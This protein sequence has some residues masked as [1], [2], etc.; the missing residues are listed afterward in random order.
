[1][2]RGIEN[3]QPLRVLEHLADDQEAVAHV[4]AMV[5]PGLCPV[6]AACQ[7]GGKRV[8]SIGSLINDCLGGGL[9]TG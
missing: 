6:Q 9:A 5:K 2:L 8:T 7:S 4:Y 1:M 3:I